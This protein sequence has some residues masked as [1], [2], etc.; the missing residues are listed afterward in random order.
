MANVEKLPSGRWRGRYVDADGKKQAVPGTFAR[1]SD[2]R[3]AAVEAQAKAKRVTAAE[4]G[5]LSA[6]TPWLAWWEILNEDRV[7]TSDMGIKQSQV[8][9]KYVG[10]AW[11]GTALNAFKR[12]EVQAWIDGLCRQG[13]SANYVRNIYAPLHW[14]INM[15]VE[16]E[17]LDA[18][19]L[20]GIKLPRR[21]KRSKKFVEVGEPSKL[22]AEMPTRYVDASDFILEVGCRPGE[23][24]GLHAEQLDLDHGWVAIVYA[25]VQKLKAMRPNPK[26][27]DIR[28]APLSTKAI[29]IVKRQLDGRSLDEGCGVPHT[30]GSACTSP[31]VFRNLRGG[32]LHPDRLSQQLRDAARELGMKPKSSYALRRGFATR[33]IEGGA[34]VFQVQ[35]VMGHADLEELAGYVQETS[36]ARSRLLAALGERPQLSVV[37]DE[38]GTRGTDRGTDSDNQAFPTAPNG[39]ETDAG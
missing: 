4:T 16:Q 7:H 29:E 20:V 10:P 14:S 28:K 23:L 2:A 31:L 24:A 3:D 30:D 11:G 32:V 6:K 9:D 35:R 13:H 5:T 39:E 27:D 37:D 17:V 38:R 19:P 21:P 33:A 34:D 15:A 8:V 18:T 12:R 1:K 36:A 26:D 25:Y 22:G